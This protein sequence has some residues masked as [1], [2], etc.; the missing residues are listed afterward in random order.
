MCSHVPA[1]NALF[2]ESGLDT[3]VEETTG[4]GGSLLRSASVD[5]HVGRVT[6]TGHTFIT[7]RSNSCCRSAVSC[8]KHTKIQMWWKQI[9]Q[10]NICIL[11]TGCSSETMT[12][13]EPSV[14]SPAVPKDEQW[15]RTRSSC[16]LP[17]KPVR[18]ETW[19][20]T[21]LVHLGLRDDVKHT[22]VQ[23]NQQNTCRSYFY[24]KHLHGCLCWSV[25]FL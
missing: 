17:Q 10:N 23:L 5:R 8:S 3:H 24:E 14:S 6:W 16:V 18:H 12:S 20:H 4:G 2:K 19:S 13:T 22:N 21:L 11:H 15:V 25:T 1:H 7:S 9:N